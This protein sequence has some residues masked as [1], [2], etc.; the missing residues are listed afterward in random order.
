MSPAA[1]T[2]GIEVSIVSKSAL[3]VPHLDTCKL[4]SPNNTGK[5]SG[6]KP[7]ALITR[8]ALIS[9][10]ESFSSIGFLLPL[11]SGSPSFIFEA[12]TFSTLLVPT[13]SFGFDSQINSTPSSSAF[14]TS[15]ADPGMFSL[16]LLYKHLTELAFCLTEVLTQSIAVSPPP[17]TTI[18]F[19]SAFKIPLSNNST[20]SPRPFLFEAIKNSI[21]GNIF[22]KSLPGRLISLAL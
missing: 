12:L 1:N 20:L 22:A 19:P 17:I 15:R 10:S 14:K 18:S 21:A 13:N 16:S 7:R 9:N 5:F 6:S 3:I 4:F 8:S 11:S 2:P